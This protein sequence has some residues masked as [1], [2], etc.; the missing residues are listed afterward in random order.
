MF[1]A[2]EGQDENA[3]QLG[4]IRLNFSSYF[5]KSSKNRFYGLALFYICEVRLYLPLDVQTFCY[6][7][8]KLPLDNFG[9]KSAKLL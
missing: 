5:H 9:Q 6:A 8:V 2:A 1:L 3:L 7:W 4:K